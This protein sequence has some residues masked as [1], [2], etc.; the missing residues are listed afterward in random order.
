M[1]IAMLFKQVILTFVEIIVKGNE[2]VTNIIIN[3]KIEY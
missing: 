2:V 3:L 1:I